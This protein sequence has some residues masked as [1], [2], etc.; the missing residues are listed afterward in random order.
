MRPVR[1]MAADLKRLADTA[2]RIAEGV[3]ARAEDDEVERRARA[4]AA[5]IVASERSKSRT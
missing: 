5:E 3:E 2:V 1:D 4:R